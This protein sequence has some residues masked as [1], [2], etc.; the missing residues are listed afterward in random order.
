MTLQPLIKISGIVGSSS[1]LGGVIALGIIALA[2][3]PTSIR[4]PVVWSPAPFSLSGDALL[5]KAAIV[6]DPRSGTVLFAKNSDEPLP[7]ASLTKLMAAEAILA[8]QDENMLVTIQPDDLRPEG[9]SGL[10]VGDAWRIGDLLTL[11]LVS[12]SNDAMAAAAA[13]VGS[14]I[15]NE[16]N[17][18]A[19]RLGLSRTYFFNP[20][21]LDLDPEIS[22]AYGSAQDVAAL[23]TVFLR[24]YPALFG[25]S[26]QPKVALFVDGRAIEA[27]S[28]AGPLLDIPGLIGA[29]TGYT[30]LAGGNLVAA[31]DL[32]IGR[33]LIA[34]VLGSTYEGRFEDM[35]MLVEAAR[36]SAQAS[37]AEQRP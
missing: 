21:G 1:I 5:A 33:P 30:D 9:D 11:G 27:T 12:S 17:R 2:S 25:T 14:N 31:F 4:P 13:S 24:R 29:K 35:R 3:S 28:T 15:M 23:T 32:A 16:M 8:L 10:R 34:V 6:Y 18:S 7:L 22:G 19:S 36:L 20:T 37:T 26:V